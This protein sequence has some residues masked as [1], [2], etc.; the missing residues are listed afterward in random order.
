MSFKS[1][2]GGGDPEIDSELSID[3]ITFQEVALSRFKSEDV[4]IIDQPAAKGTV[5]LNVR[6]SGTGATTT[7]QARMVWAAQ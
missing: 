7:A 4:K 5:K 3:A 1:Y 2:I 6:S